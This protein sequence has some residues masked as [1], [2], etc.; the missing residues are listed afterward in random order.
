MCSRMRPCCWKGSPKLGHLQPS[1]PCGWSPHHVLEEQ[2]TSAKT[3]SIQLFSCSNYLIYTSLGCFGILHTLWWVTHHMPFFFQLCCHICNWAHLYKTGFI[4]WI[5]QSCRDWNQL[6]WFSPWV[7]MVHDEAGSV[8]L[9][10]KKRYSGKPDEQLMGYSPAWWTDGENFCI[11]VNNLVINSACWIQVF[12]SWGS[13]L[14]LWLSLLGSEQDTPS[15]Y[16][17]GLGPVCHNPF[18]PVSKD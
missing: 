17:Q 14:S 8:F 12:I 9:W 18:T 3:V 10:L 1:A 6:H 16:S 11:S 7:W 5:C 13:F 15:T 4:L 2:S